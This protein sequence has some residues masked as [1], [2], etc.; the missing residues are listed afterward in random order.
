MMVASQRLEG[1][2]LFGHPIYAAVVEVID[3]RGYLQARIEDFLER[4][5][6]SREEFDRQFRDKADATTRVLEALIGNFETRVGRAF[7][8]EPRWPDNLRAAAY[9]TTRWIRDNPRGTRFGMV[10]VL[11]AGDFP[12]LRREEV[13]KWCAGLID[14]GREV[15]PDPDAV[16]PAAPLIAVGAIAE[17]LRRQ[18]EGTIETGIVETVAPMMYAAVRPYLGEEA[19][20]RELEIAPPPDLCPPSGWGEE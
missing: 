20:L 17:T 15:A 9:E 18:Q 16:P 14:R 8:C 4:S 12:R 19:A 3:E 2:P 6:M 10:G 13:F 11:D 7:A 5:G 1:P